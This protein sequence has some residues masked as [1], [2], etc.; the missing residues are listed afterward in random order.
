MEILI[1]IGG[2]TLKFKETPYLHT[3][4]TMITYC[5][6]D[7]I[8]FSCDIFSTHVANDEIFIDEANVDIT[9]DFIGYYK[10]NYS[11]T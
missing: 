10:C 5:I 11:S 3:E 9:E 2:K 8:L 6:E 1:D 7:K 4:E